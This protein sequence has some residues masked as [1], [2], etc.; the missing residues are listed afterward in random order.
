MD[1][2]GVKQERPKSDTHASPALSMRIFVDLMSP[3]MSLRA[4]H[5]LWMNA[6]PL[7]APAAIFNRVVQSNGVR[8]GPLFPATLEKGGFYFLYEVNSS[9]KCTEYF[10]FNL[11][12]LK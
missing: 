5:E 10:V 4:L 1:E 8:P 6:T 12:T 7:A 3:W 2:A 11:T 9:C